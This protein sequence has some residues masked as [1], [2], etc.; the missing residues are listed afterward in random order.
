MESLFQIR[1]L[2][3]RTGRGRTVLSLAA[4]LGVLLLFLLPGLLRL[5]PLFFDDEMG[6]GFP[7]FVAVARSLQNGEIPLWDPQ[8]FCGA[9][10]H[11]AMVDTPI[12][13][14][15]LYPF[16]LLANPDNLNQA[17]WILWLIPY[18]L[19]VLAAGAGAFV[20]GRRILRLTRTGAFVSG[21]LY[22]IGPHVTESIISLTGT[23]VFA[24]LPWA[25]TGAIAFLHTGWL[26]WWLLGAFS[27]SAMTLSSIINCTLRVYVL[28][29]FVS[30]A[31]WA[32][33][34]RRDRSLR[35]VFRLPLLA[36][37][38][39]ASAGLAGLTWSGALEGVHWIQNTAALT[40][41]AIVRRNM[42]NLRPS[43][44]MQLFIPDFHGLLIGAHAWGDAVDKN[45]NF[46]L[47]GGLVLGFGVLATAVFWFRRKATG[48]RQAVW[49]TW[50]MIAL[51]ATGITLLLLLGK[52]TPFLRL[53]C[54]LLPW[55]FAIPYAWYYLFA[56]CWAVSLLAGLAVSMLQTMPE[57]RR[58]CGHW[59][60]VA[61]Y[62]AAVAGLCALAL[63]D[64]VAAEKGE[65]L[66]F[67]SLT[68]RA[69]WLW[70]LT[71]PMLYFALTGSA[72]LLCVLRWPRHWTRAMIL[73]MSVEA[74][75]FGYAFLYRNQ[76]VSRLQDKTPYDQ[77]YHRR[78]LRPEDHPFYK[79][80]PELRKLAAERQCR[81]T[82]DVSDSDNLAWLTGGRALFGYDAKPLM[83]RMQEMAVSFMLDWP[84][85]MWTVFMPTHFL[86]NMNTGAMLVHEGMLAPGGFTQSAIKNVPVLCLRDPATTVDL[87]YKDLIQGPGLTLRQLPAPLPYVYTQDRVVHASKEEQRKRLMASDLRRAVFVD[88]DAKISGPTL[89]DASLDVGDQAYAQRFNALQAENRILR[90]ERHA[91]SL[92]LGTDIRKPAMLVIAEAYHEGWHAKVDGH[93][94]TVQPV[95]YVQQ[96]VW[97]PAGTQK[98]ELRFWPPSLNRGVAAAVLS[99]FL[100]LVGSVGAVGVQAGLRAGRLRWIAHAGA[101]TIP[102]SWST[103][104]AFGLRQALRWLAAAA[105]L[106]GPFVSILYL[107]H[108]EPLWLERIYQLYTR[109]PH[110][111]FAQAADAGVA[112]SREALQM[113]RETYFERSAIETLTRLWP[114]RF[115]APALGWIL[116]CAAALCAWRTAKMPRRGIL[117]VSFAVFPALAFTAGLLFWPS[118]HVLWFTLGATAIF[119]LNFLLAQQPDPLRARH[120]APFWLTVSSLALTG[121]GHL[122]APAWLTQAAAHVTGARSDRSRKIARHIGQAFAVILSFPFLALLFLSLRPIPL[123]PAAQ[124]I[125]P[126]KDL[127]EVI[128]DP[129]ARRVITTYKNTFLR[130]PAYVFN[131]DKPG[132]PRTVLIPS[133]E[134]EDL[135]LDPEG[136]RIYHVL[137]D[138]NDILTLDADTL[139]PIARHTG[140]PNL[141]GST[142]VEYA[143]ELNKVFTICERTYVG[144]VDLNTGRADFRAIGYGA[145]ILYD[146]HNRLLYVSHRPD[147]SPALVEALDPRSLAVVYRAEAPLPDKMAL[148]TRRNEL[149]LADPHTGTVW[150]LRTPRLELLRKISTQ[151]GVRPMAVDEDR[152]WLLTVSVVTGYLEVIDLESGR[153]LQQH[154]VGKYARKIALDP[155]TRQAFITLTW[156]GLVTV[157]Y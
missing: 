26:R 114:C 121:A 126:E 72:M 132:A 33:S 107:W 119:V 118:L 75:F 19:F 58:L 104:T 103:A 108:F 106:T 155:V 52:Y 112:M 4:L 10:T 2:S 82:S 102:A 139:R 50:S 157:K 20:F 44:L 154:Y 30:L 149:Y 113:A 1:W 16:F 85:Q 66:A 145:P 14:V 88:L 90:V 53:L 78:V 29:G 73:A 47:S 105:L 99:L 86:A 93:E 97:L 31:V 156:D 34:L 140:L 37:L 136:R 141:P 59:K 36:L 142:E 116:G 87:D 25:L 109:F 65:I 46:F 77:A 147:N 60:V 94:V 69:E 150:A 133:P 123:S 110:A 24:C 17:H 74:L 101:A 63:L 3:P 128:V 127:Y 18:A 137:R 32:L 43:L 71:R 38:F 79:P 92:I 28:V 153:T 13:N 95:N 98:V 130:K 134:I 48:Q 56:E 51:A 131:L 135:A 125:L 45:H 96:G 62:L 54:T 143:S 9:R 67:E 49:R 22:A 151:F 146:R 80:V 100:I 23:C 7:K 11:Y 148:S 27:L 122:F 138:S 12:F 81:F 111:W 8:T 91:N 41:E 152:G 5:E 39:L 35:N 89:S 57:F 120:P 115:S 68:S 40:Y 64:P 117:W 55:F 129:V 84:Y 6:N 42:D 21:L 144:V 124:L 61:G 83:L 76:V 15:F 70:F